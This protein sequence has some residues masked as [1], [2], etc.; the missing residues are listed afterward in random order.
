MKTVYALRA[1]RRINPN[2]PRGPVMGA[3]EFTQD[4]TE[5]YKR[6]ITFERIIV[7]STTVTSLTLFFILVV[8]LRRAD[9]LA[10][11]RAVEKERFERELHQSERLA[12]V[13][14]MVAGV[15]HEIP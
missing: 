3:L 12:S 7:G 10:T 15:A 8:I 5:D 2:D 11:E 6:V 4:I 9:R 1:D 14:R 13:G